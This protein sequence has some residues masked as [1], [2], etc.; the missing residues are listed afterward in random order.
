VIDKLKIA[1]FVLKSNFRSA[2]LSLFGMIIVLLLV[3]TV[4][5]AGD[6]VT[7]EVFI[8]SIKDREF[9][10]EYRIQPALGI[11]IDHNRFTTFNRSTFIE[12]Q[13]VELDQFVSNADA[14]EPVFKYKHYFNN[15]INSTEEERFVV[16]SDSM[17]LLDDILEHSIN[18]SRIPETADEMLLVLS[19]DE[20]ASPA[21]DSI[22]NTADREIVHNS[23]T[24]DSISYWYNTSF[25][26]TAITFVD[27]LPQD[28][29]DRIAHDHGD[30]WILVTNP[31]NFCEFYSSNAAGMED[32]SLMPDFR[33]L[34]LDRHLDIRY[35]F[36][37][38]FST[39]EYSNIDKTVQDIDWISYRMQNRLPDYKL[40]TIHDISDFL[41]L[42]ST[43][44]EDLT[45]FYLILTLPVLI[46]AMILIY[47]SFSLLKY[48]RSRSMT[49]LYKH[50]ISRRFLVFYQLFESLLL[51]IIAFMAVYV[52]MIPISTVIRS[53]TGLLSFGLPVKL[54]IM[55]AKE[56]TTSFYLGLFFVIIVINRII[57]N[58]TPR[59]VSENENTSREV[60]RP[61]WQKRHLDIFALITGVSLAVLTRPLVTAYLDDPVLYR[62][63][64]EITAFFSVISPLLFLSGL[65]MLFN[66]VFVFVLHKPVDYLW[67]KDG[68]L[69]SIALKNLSQMRKSSAIA[70]LIIA[71]SI[72]F[73]YTYTSVSIS[74][75]DHQLDT[76]DYQVGA[77]ISVTLVDSVNLTT[78]FELMYSIKGLAGVDDTTL[79]LSYITSFN[80]DELQDG[81]DV[82]VVGMLQDAGKVLAVREDY[83]DRNLTELIAKLPGTNSIIVNT[84]LG[85]SLKPLL[86]KNS[87]VNLTHGQNNISLN[88]AAS[89]RYFPHYYKAISY[90]RS[91]DCMIGD[92]WYFNGLAEVIKPNDSRVIHLQGGTVIRYGGLEYKLFINLDE[93]TN[94]TA[95]IT[96]LSS[97]GGN[98]FQ[99]IVSGQELKQEIRDSL[100]YSIFWMI[101]NTN[102]LAG[103][104]VIESTLFFY[105]LE[106]L[107]ID[108][109]HVAIDQALGMSFKQH[110][111]VIL[112][113]GASILVFASVIGFITGMVVQSTLITGLN[114]NYISPPLLSMIPVSSLLSELLILLSVSLLLILIMIRKFRDPGAKKLSR[115]I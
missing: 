73:I 65:I 14:Q 56:V 85:D 61:F 88:F 111:T 97:I 44:L 106:R 77:D 35:S 25:T 99:D 21:L 42:Y 46:L 31:V 12:L 49:L 22:F 40:F 87:A 66:R 18:G 78:A 3:S 104:T 79:A 45:F 110:G 101:V 38:D 115:V 95:I 60:T 107:V 70:A 7:D 16:I 75:A 94:S 102:I 105:L 29:Q 74:I 84:A 80:H 37:F 27:T 96:A 109:R 81:L 11:T 36:V 50:G 71:L 24:N 41:Y 92:F 51:Y 4:A 90:H 114:S 17:N 91:I 6:P 5:V 13:D 2:L 54:K 47:H 64:M 15:Q 103:L 72:C 69:I 62:P 33:D 98:N 53:S 10:L 59:G 55:T 48:H 58:T 89:F 93:E 28:L 39:I 86:D 52:L 68:G 32:D 112:I 63:L 100:E 76:V 43:A 20:G 67:E 1:W 34:W 57:S 26:I 23:I 113:E 8:A 108:R 9:K 19:E 83:S 30:C 82:L